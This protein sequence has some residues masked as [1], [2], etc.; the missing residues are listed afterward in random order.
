MTLPALTEVPLVDIVAGDAV[1]SPDD[2]CFYFVDSAVRVGQR[3]TLV[4]A[5]GIAVPF[6]LDQVRRILRAEDPDAAEIFNLE[7]GWAA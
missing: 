4:Y 3:L 7:K 1:W 6:D 2:R 5:G